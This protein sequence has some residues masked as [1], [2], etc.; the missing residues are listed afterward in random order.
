MDSYLLKQLSFIIM[1][2][3]TCFVSS[4]S[5]HSLWHPEDE[6]FP[7]VHPAQ[8]GCHIQ[9]CVRTGKITI[10]SC[11][12]SKERNERGWTE[13][14]T[15]SSY[16]RFC[17]CLGTVVSIQMS[18]AAPC[19]APSL[20]AP[21]MLLSSFSTPATKTV[22]KQLPSTVLF[23]FFGKKKV[24]KHVATVSS[25]SILMYSLVTTLCLQYG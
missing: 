7:Q 21:S 11:V 18:N 12:K 5:V 22:N 9:T 1:S 25:G 6:D 24:L 15:E 19:W 14:D 2:I 10:N 16:Q 17:P 4:P 20:I 13:K 3:L 23:C 8:L